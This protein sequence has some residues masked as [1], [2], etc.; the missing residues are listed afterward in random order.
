MIFTTEQMYVSW[1]EWQPENVNTDLIISMNGT[2][3]P[4]G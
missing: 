1:L 3:N 2:G 4:W